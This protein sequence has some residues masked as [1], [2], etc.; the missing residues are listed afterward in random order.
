M[1]EPSVIEMSGSDHSK[2]YVEIVNMINM[3]N[4]HRRMCADPDCGVTLYHAKNTALR[5]IPHCW[6]TERADAVL[7]ITNA[8]W[9]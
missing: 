7:K 3:A 6:P 4:F 5:L 8:R 1:T 9:T 2:A